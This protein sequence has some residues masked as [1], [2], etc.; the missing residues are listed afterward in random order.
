[1]SSK[2]KSYG[3][4]TLSQD[5]YASKIYI[6]LLLLN[7]THPHQI[8]WVSQVKDMFNSMGLGYIWNRQKVS[9]EKQFLTLFKQR[10]HDMYKQE[11]YGEISNTSDGRLYKLIKTNLSLKTI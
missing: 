8:T 2:P 1:M 9:N 6:Q 4:Q 11:W 5:N 7:I 10:L 3:K